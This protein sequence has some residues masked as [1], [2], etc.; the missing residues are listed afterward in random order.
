MEDTFPGLNGQTGPEDEPMNFNELY[1]QAQGLQQT[2]TNAIQAGEGGS[3][4]QSIVRDAA[5]RLIAAATSLN[6][7]GPQLGRARVYPEM[8]WTDILALA[9]AISNWANQGRSEQTEDASLVVKGA[10]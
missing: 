4:P 10:P 5:Q 2:A 6:G 8:T 9:L 1:L 7:H 3:R